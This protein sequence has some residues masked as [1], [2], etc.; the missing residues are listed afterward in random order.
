MENTTID[1]LNSKNPYYQILKTLSIHNGS[2]YLLSL[3][4]NLPIILLERMDQ[5]AALALPVCYNHI[6]R[7]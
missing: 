5:D 3:S 2:A 4:T 1:F 6:L 7:S